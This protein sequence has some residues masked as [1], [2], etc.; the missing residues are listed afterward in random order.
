[1]RLRNP[2]FSGESR[3]EGS[4]FTKIVLIIDKIIIIVLI[5][6][7]S[8]NGGMKKKLLSW[9]APRSASNLDR[10]IAALVAL[11]IYTVLISKIIPDSQRDRAEV[12]L[13]EQ[14]RKLNIALQVHEIFDGSIDGATN[15]IEALDE[16]RYAGRVGEY[17]DFRLSGKMQDH[18]EAESGKAR[19]VWNSYKQR[20]EVTYGMIP[21]IKRFYHDEAKSDP[22]RITE[23]RR[24]AARES[25]DPTDWMW[26]ISEKKIPLVAEVGRG[27]SVAATY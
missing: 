24:R 20:F 7:I 4:I 22:V 12:E 27:S 16:L 2:Q 15:P 17:V 23:V 21:G 9:V 6:V 14:V 26:K 25:A 5:V 19:A 13:A 11:L 1:M 8:L 10:V 18:G 3:G